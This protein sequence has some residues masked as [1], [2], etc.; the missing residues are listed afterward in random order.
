MIIEKKQL[1][2]DFHKDPYLALSFF[3]YNNDLCQK[4]LW[5]TVL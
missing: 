1:G 5:M 4:Y 2:A 3:M